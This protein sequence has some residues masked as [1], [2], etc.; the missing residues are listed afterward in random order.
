M[1]LERAPRRIARRSSASAKTSMT[2]SVPQMRAKMLETS[3]HTTGR[4]IS[5]H[6]EMRSERQAGQSARNVAKGDPLLLQ[7]H[8][9]P[10]AVKAE[11]LEDLV[12]V[13]RQT[14]KWNL[15]RLGFFHPQ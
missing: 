13:L 11:I 4:R 8:P 14:G 2:F 10:E 15:G 12:L 6:C 3:S 5:A 9:M 1:C 7:P